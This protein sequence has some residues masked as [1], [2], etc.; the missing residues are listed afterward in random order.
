MPGPR[1]G[2]GPWCA[3]GRVANGAPSFSGRGTLE[4]PWAR[5]RRRAWPIVAIGGSEATQIGRPERSPHRLE[6]A[7]VRPLRPRQKSDVSADGHSYQRSEIEKW[8]DTGRRTSPMTNN[9][10][11]SRVLTPNHSLK[12][13]I[14]D[15]QGR[16][17]PQ[18]VTAMVGEIAMADDPKAVEKKLRSL[19]QGQSGLVV[20]DGASCNASGLR[21]PYLEPAA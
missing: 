13:Q 16:S 8:F 20:G 17:N 7:A 11:Q 1:S 14:K 19:H 2:L 12:S 9:A 21:R 10:L 6:R 18:W 3:A 15:W 5:S 4:A